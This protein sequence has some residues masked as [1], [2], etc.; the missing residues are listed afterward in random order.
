MII[1]TYY[2][3]IIGYDNYCYYIKTPFCDSLYFVYF[4]KAH[5]FEIFIVFYH[6]NLG[7]YDMNRK[8]DHTHN[9]SGG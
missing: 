2:N 1:S 3:I 7:K 4:V 5:L 9:D 8:T 6:F